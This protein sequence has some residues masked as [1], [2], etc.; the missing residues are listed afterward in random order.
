MKSDDATKTSPQV[1]EEVAVAFR[2]FVDAEISSQ[3]R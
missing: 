2:N 3:A 1:L